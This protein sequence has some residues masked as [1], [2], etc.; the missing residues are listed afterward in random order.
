MPSLTI[1]VTTA[2]ATRI[3]LALGLDSNAAV[4]THVRHYLR[5][6]V[7]QAERAAAVQSTLDGLDTTEAAD[8]WT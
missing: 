7:Q 6:R 1:T 4:A 2:Q 3:K 5:E 8:N